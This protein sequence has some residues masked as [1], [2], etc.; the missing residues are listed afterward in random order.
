MSGK[1]MIRNSSETKGPIAAL[2]GWG[3]GRMR[4][5]IK[6]SKIFESQNF[7][8]ICLTTPLV[9]MCLK[10]KDLSNTYRKQVIKALEQLTKYDPARE[11]ILMAFSQSGAN[12]LASIIQYTESSR[13]QKFNIVGTIFESGPMMYDMHSITYCQNAVWN[14]YRSKPSRMTKSAVDWAIKRIVVHQVTKNAF[15]RA[16]EQTLKEYSSHKPQLMLC[17]RGDIVIDVNVVLDLCRERQRRGVPVYMNIWDD[18]E[19][20]G[21]FRKHPKEYEMILKKFIATCIPQENVSTDKL[22]NQSWIVEL[23]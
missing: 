21:M 5:L 14:G 9:Q 7:S 16:F 6:Y 18:C 19:H 8:T 2:F 13:S 23:I 10:P 17:S 22:T 3:N 20:V 12:V 11:I 1:I 15:C 4:H